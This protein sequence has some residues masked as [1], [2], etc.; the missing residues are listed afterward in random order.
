MTSE[1]ATTFPQF[2][3]SGRRTGARGRVLSLVVAVAIAAC[4]EGGGDAAA[5]NGVR[6]P[7]FSADSAYALLRRQVEFGPRVPGTPGHAAQLDWMTS[8]LRE[9]ADTVIF[10]QFSYETGEKT[11]ELTNVFARFRPD[12]TDRILL[13]AHWDTRPTADAERD[14]ARRQQPIPGANDGA[15]GVAV[16][17]EMARLFHLQ[18]PPVG[19]DI[20]LVDGEDYGPYSEDMYLGAKH[21]AATMSAYRPLYGILVDMV[22]D[23]NPRFPMEGN[24]RDAAPEVV[25]RV[26]RLA[27]QMGHGAVFERRNGGYVTDDHVELNRAGIRT[28]DI[29]DFDYGPANGYWHSLDDDVHHTSPRGLGVVGSVLTALVY[30]GG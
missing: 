25:E 24:S 21:F 14:P 12:L 3:V 27:E 30:R 8:L 16:L 18:A 2:L 19:V 9:Y 7:E 17:L 6:G 10:Q 15:S 11:L 20:L 4:S 22:G 13:L 23:E 28:I 1:P 5:Q 29:I 26:W